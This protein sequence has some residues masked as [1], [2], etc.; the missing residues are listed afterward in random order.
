MRTHSYFTKKPSIQLLGFFIGENIMKQGRSLEQIASVVIDNERNKRDFICD[1]RKLN[2]S[3]GG[4]E[5]QDI[6]G[7]TLTDVAHGQ[8][9]QRVGIP[10]RYYDRMRSDAPHLLTDNVNHWFEANP[11]PR[12]LRT[13]NGRARAFLSNRY[14]I[15]DHYNLL[16]AILPKLQDTG[17]DFVS[18]EVTDRKLYLKCLFPRIEREVSVGDLV[19]AGLV[20]SNS[21]VG[22]GSVKVEPLIYR[23]VCENGLIAPDGGLSKYH[24]GR[25]MN[26]DDHALEIYREET[27]KQ[28]DT[29]FF[30]QVADV[31]ESLLKPEAFDG[32]VNRLRDAKE[33]RIT[34]IP[35]TVEVTRKQLSLSD[36]ERDGVLTALVEGGNP[37]IYGLINAVTGMSQQVADYDRATELEKGAWGLLEMSH[38]SSMLN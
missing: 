24:L 23:L 37:S 32:L 22:L 12:L 18:M 2:M 33:R 9:A 20:I 38:G 16:N 34:D 36:D 17:C 13:L 30:M 31:V 8:I 15:L 21:E 4:L 19:Q 26:N 25:A 28:S 1:T 35:E 29:A 14:R 3:E 6:G 7:F 5:V 11:E 27:I 10:Q